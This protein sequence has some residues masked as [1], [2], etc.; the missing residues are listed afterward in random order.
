MNLQ[1]DEDVDVDEKS[2]TELNPDLSEEN[3]TLSAGALLTSGRRQTL[4][5]EIGKTKSN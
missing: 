5:R 1:V 2:L 4:S 3:L